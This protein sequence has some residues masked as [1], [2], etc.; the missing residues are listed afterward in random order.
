MKINHLYAPNAE[1]NKRPEH[2]PTSDFIS[3]A[4][5]GAFNEQTVVMRLEVILKVILK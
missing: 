3:R 2:F 5:D 1:F 4:A